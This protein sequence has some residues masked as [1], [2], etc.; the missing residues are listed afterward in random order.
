[1]LKRQK[2]P[3]NQLA[4]NLKKYFFCDRVLE[5][6]FSVFARNFEVL[7]LASFRN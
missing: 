2:C 5:N 1:M 3:S 6:E 4:T 7:I